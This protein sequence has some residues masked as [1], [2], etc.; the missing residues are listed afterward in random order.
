M[1]TILDVVK[2]LRESDPPL[3]YLRRDE[4]VAYGKF[5]KSEVVDWNGRT[6]IVPSEALSLPGRPSDRSACSNTQPQTRNARLG[7]RHDKISAT[8]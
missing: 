6:R 3:T 1:K 8:Y 7:T 4:S 5:L 2:D